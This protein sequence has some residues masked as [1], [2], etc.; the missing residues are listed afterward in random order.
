[1]YNTII[2]IKF[3]VNYTVFFFKDIGFYNLKNILIFKTI[4]YSLG[5]IVKKRA[6]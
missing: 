5:E 3:I 2:I 1:M 4:M 6:H